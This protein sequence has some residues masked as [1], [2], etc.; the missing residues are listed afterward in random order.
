M[1]NELKHMI[2]ML[3]TNMK[4]TKNIFQKYAAKKRNTLESMLVII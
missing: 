1:F 2:V 4:L 3:E